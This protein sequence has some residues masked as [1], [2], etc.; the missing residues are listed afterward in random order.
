MDLH[1]KD[2]L[3]FCIETL[4]IALH[5]SLFSLIGLAVFMQ[6]LPYQVHNTNSAFM[7]SLLWMGEWPSEVLLSPCVYLSASVSSPN[8][9]NNIEY[10]EKEKKQIIILIKITHFVDNIYVS[11]FCAYMYT[12]LLI[13]AEVLYPQSALIF[14]I[15]SLFDNRKSSRSNYCSMLGNYDVHG[16]GG[17]H[18]IYSQDHH[19]H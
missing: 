7:K 5:S 19:Y 16:W 2:H 1:Q 18:R 3:L 12:M 17:I 14:I 9:P 10:G 6:H 15:F 8:L 13:F 4:I 11:I